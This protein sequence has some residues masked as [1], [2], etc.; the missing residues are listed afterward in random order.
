[1]DNDRDS[2]DE[3]EI[4][5][6]Q[7]D[8]D[9]GE[10]LFGIKPTSDLKPKTEDSTLLGSLDMSDPTAEVMKPDAKKVQENNMEDL[11]N[12]GNNDQ[13]K[14]DPLTNDFLKQ[15]VHDASEVNAD[16]AKAGEFD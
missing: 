9:A 6:P 7:N 5:R 12:F 15:V 16:S 11:I 2:D 1:L 10:D 8:F 3:D 14:D 13:K 4:P